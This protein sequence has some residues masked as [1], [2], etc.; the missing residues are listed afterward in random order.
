MNVS[1][2]NYVELVGALEA[3][4]PETP[5]KIILDEFTSDMSDKIKQAGRYVD[6][7]FLGYE[8]VPSLNYSIFS[9]YCENDEVYHINLKTPVVIEYQEKEYYLASLPRK[10][11]FQG[12][13][14]L[15]DGGYYNLVTDPE[16]PEDF[17]DAVLLNTDYPKFSNNPYIIGLTY[18]TM[19]TTSDYRN[20]FN[21]CENL[22][23][24]LFWGPC[25][26]RYGNL[27][28]ADMVVNCPKLTM[29]G[30]SED[31]MVDVLADQLM[32]NLETLITT[33]NVHRIPENA[34]VNKLGIRPFSDINVTGKT[35]DCFIESRINEY[36]FFVGNVTGST[37]ANPVSV[38]ISDPENLKHGL[39]ITD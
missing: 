27:Q 2:D 12:N 37:N 1:I 35:E 29:M 36:K 9:S 34:S 5:Y 15:A 30:I 22:E 19:N 25:C 32:E 16:N 31:D 11:Y 14:Y 18:F 8:P 21:N 39:V 7:T 26:N 38:V 23:Y 17:T 20:M 3:N 28:K 10:M 13:Y 24:V 33:Y 4:T 6:I